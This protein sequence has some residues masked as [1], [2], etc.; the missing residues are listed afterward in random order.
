MDPN[1]RSF[2]LL[3]LAQKGKV[4]LKDVTNK[5]S[6]PKN[7]LE[8]KNFETEIESDDKNLQSAKENL[9]EEIQKTE[10][11]FTH[12]IDYTKICNVDEIENSFDNDLFSESTLV[13]TAKIN[14]EI[15]QV[16]EENKISDTLNAAKAT[17]NITRE[18]LNTVVEEERMSI[19]DEE[20]TINNTIQESTENSNESLDEEYQPPRKRA[21]R[22]L[23]NPKTWQYNVHK[24]NREKGIEYMGRKNNKFD[25]KK[26][27]SE[28]K[29][30]CSCR[31]KVTK[32]VVAKMAC[33][34]LT[35]EERLKINTKFWNLTWSERKIYVSTM[36]LK[37]VPKRARDRKNIEVS[38]RTASYEYFLD[39]N[40]QHLN[41]CKTMFCNTLGVSMRTIS[42]WIRISKSSAAGTV[43]GQNEK[44][45]KS[46]RFAERKQ[47]LLNFLTSLP[48]LESHY[49][50]KSTQKLYLEP[51]FKTKS[52]LYDVYK[53]D[54]CLQ[55]KT[56]ALSI[57]TLSN[58]FEDLNLA[59][60]SPKKDECDVCVGF[61]TKNIEESIYT[62]HIAK[63]EEARTEKAE[64][65]N[66]NNKVFT[67]DL[68]SVL[69]CP[70][71]NVSALYYRT[72]L[73]VHNF[74][75]FD[76]GTK[77]G[78]CYLWHE[79]EGELNANCFSSI[80]CDFLCTKIIP[81][82]ESTQQIILFSDGCSA[83][84]R[85]CTLANALLNLAVE[86]GVCIIQKYLE[87]GHTQME[88]DSVHSTIEQKLKG[89]T[90]NV[91]ADYVS[92]CKSARKNPKPYEV[93]YLDHTYFKDF[94]TLN[95][96]KSIRPGHK[97]GDPTVNNLRAL[98]YSPDGTTEFKIRHSEEFTTL[99]SR[100][101]K[102]PQYLPIE[103]LP[104][105]YKDKL[106]IKKEKFEHL[107]FLKQFMEKDY[108][109]FYDSLKHV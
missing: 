73:I 70:K 61:K 1:S 92:L 78:Y 2:K 68:Q 94:S 21:K 8:N 4:V 84:N 19:S 11:L 64:D 17:R 29:I 88:C 15:E 12:G 45:R 40:G 53:E 51:R 97:V 105:L 13:Q 71:S 18:N 47:D 50:R 24:N 91:P 89:R 66:S 49:C 6:Q 9:L 38:Q 82:L 72:K 76:L 5:H 48:K 67:M 85:N 52:E 20:V 26:N 22:R 33:Y 23:S 10:E 42:E 44:E 25:V 77:D 104:V 99:P 87:K 54:W 28:L 108:H 95:L 59:L 109:S 98:K 106:A 46:S 63:K 83:Q 90:I 27:K 100:A 35:E 30:R 7:R 80:I 81:Q 101:Q 32:R 3:S 39:E 102:N 55:H 69:L 79:G 14:K 103:S 62:E 57:A 65:K 37:K 31:Q 96:L 34:K 36:V 86:K 60:F 16:E 43:C 58:M 75:I 107:M 74:T 56:E 93:Y 41:V